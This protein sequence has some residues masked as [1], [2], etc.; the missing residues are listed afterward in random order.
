MA[1]QTF[2]PLNLQEILRVFLDISTLSCHMHCCYGAIIPQIGNVHGLNM[3]IY[4]T[5]SYNKKKEDMRER[6]KKGTKKIE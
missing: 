6:K 4:N 5:M 2:F 3:D 1:I